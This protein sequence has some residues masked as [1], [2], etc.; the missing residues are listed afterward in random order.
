MSP[1]GLTS[2]PALTAWRWLTWLASPAAPLLLRER[3]AR[4]APRAR[5]ANA[6]LASKARPATAPTTVAPTSQARRKGQ[7]RSRLG[8]RR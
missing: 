2:T 5:P 3:A 1:P 8:G 7:A 4:R 6:R